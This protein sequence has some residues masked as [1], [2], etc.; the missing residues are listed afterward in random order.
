MRDV[1]RI[2]KERDPR[3]P[4]MLLGVFVGVWAVAALIGLAVGWFVVFVVLGLFLAVTVTMGVFYRR[5]TASALREVEGMP[6][7]AAGVL[8]SMR[9]DWQVT[10]AVAF[11]ASQDLVHR[12]VGRPGVIL[13]GEGNPGRV[14][15][16]IAQER[17]RVNRVAAEVPVTEIVVGEG[18][19]QVPL[20]K[21]QAHVMRLP[22]A[23]KPTQTSEVKKRMRALGGPQPPIPKGPVPKTPRVPRG[24]IR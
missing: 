18:D 13:V 10:P 15:S 16:L 1:Y 12:V 17:R 7:A 5:A 24:K 8:N 3:L 9:G 20:R 6:G 14:R 23:L 19:G 4:L 11:N 21:L 22:R 2:T